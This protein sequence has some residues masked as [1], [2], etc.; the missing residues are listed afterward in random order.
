MASIA[1]RQ[2]LAYQIE[3]TRPLIVGQWRGLVSGKENYR[4]RCQRV[5]QFHGTPGNALNKWAGPERLVPYIVV[6]VPLYNM[7]L[8]LQLVEKHSL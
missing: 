5:V 4:S 7:H 6:L 8:T 2:L 3:A 1:S